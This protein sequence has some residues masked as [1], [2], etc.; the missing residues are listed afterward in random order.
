MPLLQTYEEARLLWEAKGWGIT[1]VA[2][3]LTKKPELHN[4]DVSQST[5]SRNTSEGKRVPIE[6]EV[7]LAIEAL[8]TQNW[9]QGRTEIVI[10]GL[11][12]LH[13]RSPEVD[14]RELALA[15][16]A[17]FPTNEFAL[18]LADALAKQADT[19]GK[20]DAVQ[21]TVNHLDAKMDLA[22]VKLDKIAR[23]SWA[24]LQA[25]RGAM[26]LGGVG[27]LVSVST[28]VAVV[29]QR[30]APAAPVQD[31]TVNIRSA[32]VEA[33]ACQRQTVTPAQVHAMGVFAPNSNQ[34]GE[35]APPPPSERW[36]PSQPF[37]WQKLPPCDAGVG[38]SPI[39]GGCW[40][41]SGDV[42]PPC[43]RL[44]RNGD[45]CYRPIAADPERPVGIDPE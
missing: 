37:P 16:L 5:L 26:A 35:K 18:K 38:E 43:G 20:L 34:L 44:F 8:E 3:Y 6:P 13:G 32:G 27:V 22:D 10:A 25:L 33:A 31:V 24:L 4:F 14:A 9:Y 12:A 40:Y 21:A 17:H 29:T 45:K 1:K 19:S 7:A 11:R 41:A 36:V 42:K 15:L 28:C 23:G 30:S 2:E 39:N